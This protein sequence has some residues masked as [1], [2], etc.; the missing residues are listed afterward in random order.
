MYWA[1]KAPPSTARAVAI[2]C[3]AMAPDATPQGD[4]PKK[5]PHLIRYHCVKKVTGVLARHEV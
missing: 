2:T 1:R 5:N 4:C 3:P